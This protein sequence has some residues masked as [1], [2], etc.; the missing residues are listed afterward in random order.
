MVVISND[1]DL[2]FPVAQ[3]R[4]LVPA[5]TVNP[6][7]SYVAGALS[8]DASDGV[9]GHRWWQLA[10]TDLT[11]AQLLPQVGKLTRPPEWRP[12]VAAVGGSHMRSNLCRLLYTPPG[13]LVGRVF[14]FRAD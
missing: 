9:G 5:G 11:N 7:R 13:P 3:A 14:S 4:Q 6:T 12:G 1:S 8:A 10:A 2:A